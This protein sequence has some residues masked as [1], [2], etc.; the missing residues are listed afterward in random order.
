MSNEPEY[1]L[2][3]EKTGV[4]VVK[5]VDGF[6]TK[7]GHKCKLGCNWWFNFQSPLPSKSYQ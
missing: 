2:A 5:G 4:P 3:A 1:V 7:Q 6:A